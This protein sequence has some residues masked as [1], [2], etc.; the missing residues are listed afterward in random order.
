MAPSC[1]GQSDRAEAQEEMKQA[2]AAAGA[3]NGGQAAASR[4]NSPG[5][6]R[7]RQGGEKRRRER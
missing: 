7:S 3:P 5:G 2:Q 6:T 4:A 1:V